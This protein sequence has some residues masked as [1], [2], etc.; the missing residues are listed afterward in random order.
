MSDGI[1]QKMEFIIEQQATFA[2]DIAQMKEVQRQ[3]AANIDRLTEN[4]HETRDM[5]HETR[6]MLHET[7]DMLHSVIIEMRQGFDNLI[8]ANEVTRKLAEDVGRLAIN[9]SQ[10][11][12]LL[13]SRPEDKS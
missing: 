5:L 6:D 11:V 4:M 9:T 1:E 7:R 12:T 10:R 8:I 13:E 3:Q 2:V